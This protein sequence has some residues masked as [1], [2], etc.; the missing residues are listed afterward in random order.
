MVM[1]LRKRIRRILLENK[2]RY[3]GIFILIFIG[4]FSFIAFKGFSGNYERLINEFAQ[5]NMQEDVSF[6]GY[7]QI[8]DISSLE[9]ETGAIIDTH[10][11][12]D[13]PLHH[14]RE[15]RLISISHK[16]NIPS[17]IT[18]RMPKYPREILLSPNFYDTYG[19]EI[20]DTI[21]INDDMFEVVGTVAL[22]NYVFPLKYIN[23]VIPPPGFGLGV[24][25]TDDMD[26]FPDAVTVYTARFTDRDNVKAQVTGLYNSI[27]QKGLMLSEW[28]DASANKR[29]RM[30][31]ATISGSKAMSVP[32]PTAMFLLCCLIVGLMIWRMVRSESIIIGTLYAQGYRRKELLQHYLS[33]PLM[34]SFIAGLAGSLL[35]L[36]TIYPTI[37]LMVTLYYIVPFDKVVHS[38]T[39][40]VLGALM[41]V[42]FLG[43]ASWAVIRKELAKSPA[44]LMKG[45]IQKAKVNVLERTLKLDYLSFNNKF[46][47]RE[48]LRSIPRLI[49][50]LF[51]VMAASFMMLIGFTINNSMTTVFSSEANTSFNYSWEY[52]FKEAKQG[53]PVSGTIPFNA[54][55]SHPEGRESIEFYLTGISTDAPYVYDLVDGKGNE[56]SKEQVNISYLLAK[57]LNLSIGDR[58]TVVNKLDGKSYY[59]V[60]DG[61]AQTYAGQFIYMPLSDFNELIGMP[62]DSYKGVF[63]KAT[64]EYSPEELS[65]IK[66]LKNMVNSMDEL[67]MPMMMVVVSLTIIASIIGVIIIYLVTSLT[68][69]E[70]RG[71]I[72]LLK[73]FGY[74]SKEIKRLILSGSSPFVIA[75][76][77]LGIPVMLISATA[78]YRY[79]GE[80][81][82][83]A[84][85]MILNPLHAVISFTLLYAVY[86]FTK[87][88]CGRKLAAIPMSDAL[89]AGME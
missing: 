52:S 10:K 47:V 44:E 39:D 33:I 73:V 25:A 2:G 81:I 80:M 30:A 86:E 36:P 40:I 53:T 31:W 57:R 63:S 55:R 88:S 18:G 60:I 75:G 38:L 69:E 59:L 4:S 7:E 26:V 64:I 11:Y 5:K 9:Q 32:V 27:T 87:L 56:L 28:M 24:I 6:T 23:D 84:L 42:I 29:I 13:V 3:I 8:E 22:P 79:L 68:I 83:L 65:G 76:F 48:Q 77:I 45:D 21:K 1:V 85:P 16:V 15:L 72:S 41:P 67:M 43:L 34:V 62:T 61:I 46:K 54:I 20:G 82:N 35:A 78:L 14:E 51:G 17:V 89:K 12:Y 70:S 37:K 50:L 49:F 19:Y 66:D 71:S 74:R 58:I